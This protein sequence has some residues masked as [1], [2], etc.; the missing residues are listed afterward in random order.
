LLDSFFATDGSEAAL[1][2]S[3]GQSEQRVLLRELEAKDINTG[4]V[5]GKSSTYL[6]LDFA[7]HSWTWQTKYR[8]KKSQ[9]Q[10]QGPS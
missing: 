8:A 5:V 7:A 2:S 1:S 4:K 10:V 6:V 9:T 3:T